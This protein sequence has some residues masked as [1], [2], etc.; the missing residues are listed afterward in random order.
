MA[1]RSVLSFL[2]VAGALTAC[3]EER[4]AS[5]RL[6]LEEILGGGNTE[7][8]LR[9]DAPRAFTFPED[10]G[11][12]R[13][14]RNEWW[15]LTGNLQTAEGR[16]FGYQ[17]TFFNSA[18]RPPDVAGADSAWDSERLWM[19]HFAITDAE[20]GTHTAVERFSRENP[21]LAGAQVAPFKV[22]LE[23]WTLAGTRND[24]PWHLQVEDEA[25]RINLD[26]P[27]SKP[28]RASG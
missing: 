11:P 1:I 23:N 28:P 7:G 8:F 22:W 4:V 9:A 17:V 2:L 3:S 18:M 10:H 27:N 21:G 5:S 16:R 14:F 19:A 15:Y 25:I 6:Q 20:A 26:L 13:G 12:H 24:Y